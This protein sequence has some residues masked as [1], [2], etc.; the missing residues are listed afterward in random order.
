MTIFDDMSDD[1]V[2]IDDQKDYVAELV[3]DGKKFKDVAGLARGKAEAD[4]YIRQLTE[5]LDEARKELGSR[6]SLDDFLKE[7]KTLRDPK[8][9]GDHNVVIPDSPKI[10][11]DSS[12]EEKILSILQSQQEKQI[13]E[14][15]IDRVQR[16]LADQ[17]GDNAKQV[18]NNKAKELG[19]SVVELQGLAQ[20][21]PSAFFRL[22]GVS[23]E[24]RL[25]Q[26]P[27]LPRSGVNSLAV[28]STSGVKNKAYFDK[29]KQSNPKVYWDPKT[30]AEMI[31]ARKECEQNRVPWE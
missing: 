11:D 25:S 22:V 28:P 19:M 26:T 17:L 5:R 29:L 6:T 31:K 4:A 8:P 15:N 3:G 13:G 23:E 12:L 7:M 21:S 2:T 24:P 16:V 18:I 10:P 30:T 9:N 14:S 27:S 1:T 20:K